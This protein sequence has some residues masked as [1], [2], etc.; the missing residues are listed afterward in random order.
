MPLVSSG[1]VK[2]KHLKDKLMR[3]LI[4]SDAPE[5]GLDEALDELVG[6]VEA[7]SDERLEGEDVVEVQAEYEVEGGR[8][9]W[10]EDS[11]TVKVYKPVDEV[12]RKYVEEVE[13]LKSMINEVAGEISGIKSVIS[14]VME[15]LEA[16]ERKLSE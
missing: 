13:S 9:V 10:I 5:E 6:L 7:I 16:L 14:G 2:F 15:R 4:V 3:K 1:I 8:I 11:V 12:R